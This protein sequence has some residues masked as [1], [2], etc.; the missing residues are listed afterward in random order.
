MT[1]TKSDKKVA[2]VGAGPGGLTAAMILAHR[3]LDVTVFEK[4]DHVGGRNA[5]VQLGD[6]HFDLGPTFLM[7]KFIL[8]E[9]F[10]EAGKQADDYFEYVELDPMYRL[11]FAEDHIDPSADHDKMRA[12][13]K[14]VFPGEEQNLD[15]FLSKEK[16]RFDRMIPCLQKHYSTLLSMVSAPML[17]ALPILS[18]GK[19]LYGVLGD[20]FNEEK[21]RLSFT[22]QSK[23][24]GMSP[25]NCPAAFAILSYI[26]HQFGVW[27]TQGGLS[28][29]SVN[30]AKVVEENG[31][32][33]K[34]GTPVK[35]IL[36][37]NGKAKGVLLEDDSK[38]AF[39]AVVIN[40]DFAH[41]MS[42]LVPAAKRRKYTDGKLQAMKY[43]CSTFMLYLG[44][45]KVYDMP[46]HTIVFAK[47][48]HAN[49]N[50]IFEGRLS[51]D[52][53]FYVRNAS[54]SDPKLA[55]DGHSAVYVLVP[56]ANTTAAVDW[57]KERERYRDLI[58]KA[59]AERTAMTDIADHIKEELVI[60][61]DDWRDKYSVYNGATFNLAHNI[62]QMLYFRPRNR[63]E[64]FSNCYLTGGGTHPGS[65]I[66]TILESGRISAN[67]LCRDF[68]ISFLSKN[69]MT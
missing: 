49:V 29:I 26:E 12:E 24:L 15:K 25:W 32:R 20:Y 42:E 17:K 21:L 67:L 35:E 62:G 48:Y 27:H 11:Q 40:A 61:P 44:L 13:I 45:D 30:M 28:Q 65:G 46:H 43:S 64:E 34:L 16:V 39:D 18:L 22:F 47:D 2:V 31:G 51:D 7:M 1:S 68:G 38:E 54:I 56:C 37:E 60:V 19:T 66:P 52:T 23:Y 55:P 69:I 3:G 53:S 5:D 57:P 58:L 4:E 8:E 10:D 50:D 33:L 36:V 59:I 14:R 9:V 63:F 41:A 6:Y